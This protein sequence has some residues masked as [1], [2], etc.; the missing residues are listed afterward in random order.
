MFGGDSMFNWSMAAPE[1]IAWALLIG[2]LLLAGIWAVRAR[3]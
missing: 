3:R 1:W 2:G